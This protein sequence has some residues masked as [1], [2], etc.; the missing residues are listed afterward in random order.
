MKTTMCEMKNTTDGIKG[1]LQINE[2]D[3]VNLN[4]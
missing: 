4:T 3:L 2:E 1:K